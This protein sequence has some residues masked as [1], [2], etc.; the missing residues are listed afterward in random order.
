MRAVVLA[1]SSKLLKAATLHTNPTMRTRSA[2]NMTMDV[3]GKAGPPMK[4]H[5]DWITDEGGRIYPRKKGARQP[6]QKK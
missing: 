3:K 6:Q 2:I 1:R 5:Q 4:G